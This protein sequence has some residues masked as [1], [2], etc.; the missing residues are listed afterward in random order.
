[1][2]ALR[3]K[4]TITPKRALPNRGG[5]NT[6]GAKRRGYVPASP[7]KIQRRWVWRNLRKA[8]LEATVLHP[9]ARYRVAGNLRPRRGNQERLCGQGQEDE[10]GIWH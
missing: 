2:L 3:R 7:W 8:L 6:E 10:L 1:M 9:I 5:S 4:E